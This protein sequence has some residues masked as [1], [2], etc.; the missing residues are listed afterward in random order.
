MQYFY[1]LL[2]IASLSLQHML[3]SDLYEDLNFAEDQ[4]TLSA[5]Y[6]FLHQHPNSDFT[7]IIQLKIL[8]LKFNPETRKHQ[9]QETL[10]HNGFAII[11]SLINNHCQQK[12]SL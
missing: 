8:Q 5:Y 9:S 6:H 3:L 4:N 1:V 7:S 10:M 2:I 12:D 11:S